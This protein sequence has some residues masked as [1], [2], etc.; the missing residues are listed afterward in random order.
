[1]DTL[2]LTLHL[3]TIDGLFEAPD[4]N[5]LKYSG[6]YESG[7]DTIL[8]ELH[9]ARRVDSVQITIFL[10]PDQIQPELDTHVNEAIERY[11]NFCIHK[12]EAEIQHSR[13]IARRQLVSA[14]PFMGIALVLSV[15]FTAA[16]DRTTNPVL[17]LF[18]GIFATLFSVASWIIV[19]DPIETLSYGWRPLLIENNRF[20]SLSQVELEIKSEP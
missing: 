3:N 12:N 5:P 14:L 7:M 2:H 13:R 10:P 15:L 8:E 18:A 19:W 16:V 9:K 20:R 17:Q 1:M 4:L 11:C 6:P